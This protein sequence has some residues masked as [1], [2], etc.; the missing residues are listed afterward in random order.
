MN[1][2][3]L[4]S[5]FPSDM[6]N[7]ISTLH[8]SEPDSYAPNLFDPNRIVRSR[9][10]T[11]AY[12]DFDSSQPPN[13]SLQP[14]I[15]GSG[16][17]N[18]HADSHTNSHADS[19][20]N[21]H[22]DSHTNSY[23]DSHC[24]L[25]P[26]SKEW[27][28]IMRSENAGQLV[29]YNTTNRRVSVRRLNNPSNQA[30]SSPHMCALCRRPL[31]TTSGS[32][33]MHRNYFRLLENSENVLNGQSPSTF[34][35][36]TNSTHSFSPYPTTSFPEPITEN[37]SSLSESSFNQGYYQRFFIEEKKL[38]RGS[39]GSVFLCK[40]V[41][42][43]VHL[44]EYAVK[45]VAVGDN[46]SWLVKMLREV[47]LLERLHH[48]NIIDY[49]H[50][51]L[52]HHQLTNFGPPVPCL[53]ILMERAN[54]G[55]LEEFIDVQPSSTFSIPKDS[56][57]HLTHKERLLHKKRM[58]HTGH[59]NEQPTL[60]SPLPSKRF[61]DLR[62]I[63]YLFM[64][65]CEGLAHL[66]KQGIIHRDL[67]PSNLLLQYDDPNDLSGM[68]R[69]LISDFGECEIIDQLT[70][71]DRTGAT[72]TLEF[73]APELI[74]VD[75]RGRYL[76]EYSQKSDMWSLG[77]VLYYLCYSRLPYRQND[78]VDL[79][80]QEILHFN[81]VS[82][83]DIG[84][85]SN[86]RISSQLRSLI[87]CLLSRNAKSRPSC[88]EILKSVADMRSAFV[89]GETI[90][91]T[92]DPFKVTPI[93]ES[94][95]SASSSQLEPEKLTRIP[96][97]ASTIASNLE[98]SSESTDDNEINGSKLRRRKK[99]NVET[100]DGIPTTTNIINSTVETDYAVEQGS[101]IVK[102]C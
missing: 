47:H 61:L 65:I 48:P 91:V 2:P 1:S 81:C 43:N 27:T 51:W 75:E 83:P 6:D 26:Y 13:V 95:S 32:D 22:A 68:P 99:I 30:L 79:L 97:N 46:H 23:T 64:D 100:T 53:F 29:L 72:G 35:Q 59:L 7:S 69:V 20:T 12:G 25:V 67:K 73:M 74:T 31:T 78:D 16:S 28:V 33:F 24:E 3:H 38:G 101:S 8:T 56:N 84:M 40:H 86:R 89:T 87:T 49:K 92:T 90:D 9:R 42:D 52:E 96:S 50:A 41:L 77:M 88:D 34:V 4:S 14:T 63:C 82:F 55:N 18:S 5:N 44:G 58:W 10:N 66:H 15:I 62:E 85:A 57:E 17:T 19:H 37:I 11:F 71:R 80:K 93:L 21:S 94:S 76:K 54:G 98:S 45:K 102:F 36:P 70:E 60:D 39:R